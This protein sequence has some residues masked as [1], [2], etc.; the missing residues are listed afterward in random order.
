MDYAAIL[1]HL[2][3]ADAEVHS[4]FRC[5]SHVYGTA[6][7]GSDED[8]VVVLAAPGAKKDLLFRGGANF[9]IHGQ[10]S[11]RAAIAE[12]SVFAIECLFLPSEHKL[13]ETRGAFAYKPDKRRL[14]ESAIARSD[15][16]FAK[17]ARTLSDEPRA[18]KK[19]LFHALRVPIFAFQI[20]ERGRIV[21]YG[22]ANHHYRAIMA[23]D[24]AAWDGYE[25]AFGPERLAVCEALRG[26]R[27]KR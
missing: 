5:G 9:V 21:D 24:D 26:S 12:Q 25:A 19:K 15:A 10:D 27:R 18:A 14:A 16:D 13:K 6:G 3:R 7:P 11:F 1:K 2:R 23:R 20:T 4:V 8:F 22:A 17:A